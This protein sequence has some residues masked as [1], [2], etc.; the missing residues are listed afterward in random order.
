MLKKFFLYSLLISTVTFSKEHILFIGD[1]L[2]A[3]YG[4]KKENSYPTLVK[5]LFESKLKKKIKITNGGISGSTTASGLSRLKWYSR[6]HPSIVFLALGANDGLRGIDLKSSKKNL[7][8]VINYAKKKKFKVILAGMKL[9]P[10]YGKDY[11]QKFEQLFIEIS[12]EE[13]IPLLPFLLKGV[14]GEKKYNL[15]DGIHPNEKGHQLISQNV[16]SFLKD[17]L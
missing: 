17:K 5:Q 4:V 10:N 11:A 7:I 16:F 14:A 15:D 13:K 2:T 6:L 8:S 12:K 3:G 9:P 1:S